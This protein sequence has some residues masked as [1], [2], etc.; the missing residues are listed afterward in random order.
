[1]PQDLWAEQN[2]EDIWAKQLESMKKIMEENGIIA[3]DI[4]SIGITNQRETTV[5]W[6][7]RTGQAIT[8][9]IVWSDK[10]TNLYCET[11]AKQ[12]GHDWM[13]DRSGLNFNAYFSASKMRWILD[14][15]PQANILL[16]E[17][18]LCIGTIDSYLL[19]RLTKGKSF[20]TDVSN[21]SR[22]SLMN[23]HT[24]KWDDSLLSL[25]AIPSSILPEIRPNIDNF[26]VVDALIF[27]SELPIRAMC[28]DQQSSLFGQACFSSGQAKSTY[29]TGAFILQ[30]IGDKFRLPP[31]GLVTTI[32]WDIGNGL[33]YAIEGSIFNAGTMLD[34]L[35]YE[36]NLFES[37]D[38][39][40][41][42]CAMA[43]EDQ[44]LIMVPAFDGL[45]AP[46]WD[47]G[48]RS[49]LIGFQLNTQKSDMVKS[50]IEGLV[51]Q[52]KEILD[53]INQDS[54]MALKRLKVDGGISQSNFLLQSLSNV[55]DIEIIRS[56]S[57]E[58]TAMGIAYMLW[59]DDHQGDLADLS[60]QLR[61]KEVFIPN[62]K[63]DFQLQKWRKYLEAVEK[64][65][66]WIS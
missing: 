56:K 19:F 14:H 15:I 3:K 8:N 27:G 43:S 28:G 32:A 61:G 17:G 35:K 40:D 20:C 18:N 42:I 31:K 22:T 10:R 66:S 51:F 6:D 25:F 26:G 16:A 9:A 45:G 59:I 12:Y 50:A 7:K 5:A 60:H 30:H 65:K 57:H 33:E 37:A 64:S 21:A 54:D 62:E 44:M 63:Q 53:L 4:I 39:I 52:T 23:I 48:A 41:S 36:M 11:L 29:G 49:L 47:P 46:H 1:M 24:G 38:Q 55:L 2:P 13:M 58:C 34:W